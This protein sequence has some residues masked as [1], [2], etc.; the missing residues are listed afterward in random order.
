VGSAIKGGL[1][2]YFVEVEG[3]ELTSLTSTSPFLMSTGWLTFLYP[4]RF[5]STR[6]GQLVAQTARQCHGSKVSKMKLN[7]TSR[8]EQ[9]FVQRHGKAVQPLQVAGEFKKGSARENTSD[10]GKNDVKTS[11]GK[12]LGKE[13]NSSTENKARAKPPDD[14]TSAALVE[15]SQAIRYVP[16]DL[17]L[18]DKT[19]RATKNTS[20]KSPSQS[21]AGIAP[22]GNGPLEKVLQINSSVES[23]VDDL[24]QP[25]LHPPPFVHNFDTYTLV[26]DIEA[27]GFTNKQAIT[28]MKALRVLLA[29]NLEVAKE[30][31]VS[32]G[33]V[34]NVSLHITWPRK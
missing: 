17:P 29:K 15:E 4:H 19:Q 8:S 22:R 2:S 24:K 12:A 10:S 6:V 34:E 14:S 32:K 28:T 21:K 25:H 9:R 33:D 30:G 20:K 31:L 7:T 3:V 1:S 13:R 11:G 5:R 26:K 27:G 16:S 23:A 18:G